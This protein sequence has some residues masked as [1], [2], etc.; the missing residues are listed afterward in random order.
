MKKVEKKLKR[1]RR[2]FRSIEGRAVIL[3]AVNEYNLREPLISKTLPK[4]VI[5]KER[6][7]LAN[8]I[9]SKYCSQ[10]FLFDE[11]FICYSEYFQLSLLI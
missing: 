4:K 11:R 1:K 2:S 8:K 6:K 3:K 5:Q 9:C 7:D 10:K